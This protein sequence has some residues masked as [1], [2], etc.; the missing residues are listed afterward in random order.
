MTERETRRQWATISHNDTRI[1]LELAP[2][3]MLVGIAL[4]HLSDEVLENV[5]DVPVALRGCFVE[6]EFPGLCKLVNGSA[7][8][9]ALVALW[10]R[11]G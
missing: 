4:A 3:G 1:L 10:R 11:L 2:D 6:G 5:C 8:D 7:R 9:F